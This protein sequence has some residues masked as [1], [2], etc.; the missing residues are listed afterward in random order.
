MDGDKSAPVKEEPKEES[1][2]DKAP[3]S[4]VK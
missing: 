4:T 2:W 3:L 1:L